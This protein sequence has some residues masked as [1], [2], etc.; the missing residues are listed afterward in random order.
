MKVVKDFVSR[1]KKYERDQ[2]YYP[3]AHEESMQYN[4]VD[5]LGFA[6]IVEGQPGQWAFKGHRI[7]GLLVVIPSYQLHVDASRQRNQY[8]ILSIRKES[9]DGKINWVFR[10]E[11]YPAIEHR[12]VFDIYRK[13]YRIGRRG[14]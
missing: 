5:D 8:T 7:H 10:T 12:R 1:N 2:F 6:H 13:W 14:Q 4:E 9:S 3:L 11:D